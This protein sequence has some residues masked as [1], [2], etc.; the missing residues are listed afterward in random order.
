MVLP[1]FPWYFQFLMFL[2]VSSCFPIIPWK[3]QFFIFP[4]VSSCFPIIPIKISN[5]NLFSLPWF[6]RVSLSFLWKFK[7]F[8][9]PMVFPC[10]S[11]PVFIYHYMEIW[12]FIGFPKF[13][14]Y[15]FFY[16]CFKINF[17]YRP[18]FLVTRRF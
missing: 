18:L 1:C 3:F 16:P 6:S 10:F 11:I 5:F 17:I 2:M 8:Q 13:F 9:F 15:S 14:L 12:I 4:M 7:F